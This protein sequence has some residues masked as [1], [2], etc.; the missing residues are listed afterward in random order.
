MCLLYALTNKHYS[1]SFCLI[2]FSR[3]K[4]IQY[5]ELLQAQKSSL[6]SPLASNRLL[7]FLHLIQC[8][9]LLFKILPPQIWT[10]QHINFIFSFL[11]FY[12]VFFLF[13]L[14]CLFPPNGGNTQ[15]ISPSRLFGRYNKTICLFP[16]YLNDVRK[17]NSALLLKLPT[18][19]SCS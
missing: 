19:F 3:K 9:A 16:K 6:Y 8:L 7:S 13:C 11:P 10:L 17:P 12:F 14:F 15:Q 18:F 2:D 1:L 5:I 4:P